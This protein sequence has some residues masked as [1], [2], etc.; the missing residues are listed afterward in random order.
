[1]EHSK[2]IPVQRSAPDKTSE[3]VIGPLS[4]VWEN[5][6]VVKR[7]IHWCLNKKHLVKSQERQKC[8]NCSFRQRVVCRSFPWTALFVRFHDVYGVVET[9]QS[10][11]FKRFLPFRPFHNESLFPAAPPPPANVRNRS[12]YSSCSETICPNQKVLVLIPEDCLETRYPTANLIG[13]PRTPASAP[14]F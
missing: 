7:Y 8:E 6:G 2:R 3:F 12:N 10:V 9:K 5:G 4:G 14:Y 1:M 13:R 11:L